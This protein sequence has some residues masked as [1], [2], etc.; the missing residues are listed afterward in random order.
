MTAN[1]SMS[2]GNCL[3]YTI[4]VFFAGDVGGIIFVV[5]HS[6]WTSLLFD[7][8]LLWKIW[9]C[10]ALFDQYGRVLSRFAYEAIYTWILF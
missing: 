9:I 10:G 7:D 4:I 6:S 1:V 5:C 2:L 8:C 3:S